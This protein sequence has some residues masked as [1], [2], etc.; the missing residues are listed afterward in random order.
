MVSAPP[1]SYALAVRAGSSLP[2][3]TRV[4]GVSETLPA[5]DARA[6]TDEWGETSMP[7]LQ[8]K[9]AVVACGV[10]PSL[11]PARKVNAPVTLGRNCARVPPTSAASTGTGFGTLA[12]QALR[13]STIGVSWCDIMDG[14]A[15]RGSSVVDGGASG[16]RAGTS[17]PAVAPDVAA[18]TSRALVSTEVEPMEVPEIPG[19]L[20]RGATGLMPKRKS[21]G[22]KQFRSTNPPT[23]S[24]SSEDWDSGM[25]GGKRRRITI[26]P[27]PT[28]VV[29]G[30]AGAPAL[31]N[32]GSVV[33]PR[34]ADPCTPPLDALR[35][36][37]DEL[38][39]E[40]TAYCL[41]GTK[42]INKWQMAV[43][44]AKFSEMSGIVGDLLLRN[45]RLEGRVVELTKRPPIATLMGWQADG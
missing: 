35:R 43:I 31:A 4:Y 2:M 19:I 33:A 13:S 36:K 20:G 28:P 22:G 26:A 18:S 6:S 8:S 25:E 16:A 21:R 3:P 42:K 32:G 38:T 9:Q 30:P 17:T 24:P 1:A 44:T 29:N 14:V 11:T 34:S 27:A 7:L 12:T 40:M 45:A 41:D 37:A 15:R 39:R 23:S 10:S 5:M